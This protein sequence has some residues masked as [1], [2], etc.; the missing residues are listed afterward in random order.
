MGRLDV[1]KTK[2]LNALKYSKIFHLFIVLVL[3]QFSPHLFFYLIVFFIINSVRTVD[4]TGPIFPR[5]RTFTLRIPM[6][7]GE[8]L[9]FKKSLFYKRVY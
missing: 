6:L 4:E 1:F 2:I 7:V 3:T 8:K 9:L 5:W